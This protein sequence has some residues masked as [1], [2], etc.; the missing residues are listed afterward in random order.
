MKNI[1]YGTKNLARLN[2]FPTL[3]LGMRLVDSEEGVVRA[4]TALLKIVFKDVVFIIPIF[5]YFLLVLFEVKSNFQT[6]STM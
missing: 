3:P 4:S 1:Y 2:K 6:V 5:L